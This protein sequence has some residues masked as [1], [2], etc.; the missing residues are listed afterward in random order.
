M[1]AVRAA[2]EERR[3]LL[4]QRLELDVG[5]VGEREG[6]DGACLGRYEGEV[7]VEEDGMEDPYGP[8]SLDSY[9]RVRLLVSR[10]RDATHESGKKLFH[11]GPAPTETHP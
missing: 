11:Q 8:V 7:A 1:V 9:A 5:D 10:L 6:E 4:Y 2:L 3:A